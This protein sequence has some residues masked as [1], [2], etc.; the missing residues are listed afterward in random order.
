MNDRGFLAVPLLLHAGKDTDL[1]TGHH[2][3]QDQ[4]IVLARY[5]TA[6]YDAHHVLW[7]LVAEAEYHGWG[8]NYWKQ[9]GRA[10]FAGERNHPVTLHP[11]G[12]D[13][14]LYTFVDEPWMDIVGYQS[15]HGD[16]EASLRWIP[17]DHRAGRGS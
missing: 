2:L 5:I 14:A 1:N 4:A 16:G 6:R 10:V 17:R 3:P 11:Y 7:N 9:V 12:L 8:A 15:A 13:W